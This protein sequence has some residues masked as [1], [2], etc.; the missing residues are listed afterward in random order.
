MS[1]VSVNV[2]NI[3]GHILTAIPPAV[4]QYIDDRTKYHPD[5]YDKT[6]TYNHR[7]AQG[8]RRWDGFNHTFN[9]EQR[10][11]RR[12]LLQRVY[13]ALTFHGYAPS[14][15]Q[16]GTQEMQ[17]TTSISLEPGVVT[18]YPFQEKVR[19][20]IRTEHK[21]GIIA[22]PT[23]TGKSVMMGLMCD[24]LRERTLII[25]NDLVLCDQMHRNLQRYFPKGD[26]GYI[27]NAEFQLGEVT[28]A[29]LQSLRSILG[30][31]EKKSTAP[32]AHIHELLQ[33]LKGVG[34]VLHDEVHLADCESNI[35]VYDTL[36]YTPRRF[37]FSATPYGW[38]EK[39]QKYAN[40]EL[41]QLFGHIIYSTFDQD[42]VALG[43]KVPVLVR[44]IEVPALIPVYGTFRDNQGVLYKKCLKL[45]ILENPAWHAAV[46]STAREYTEN[47]ATAFVYASHSLKYGQLIAD[48]LEAPFVNGKT[49]RKERFR[50]FDAVQAKELPCIVSDI[51][52][53]GLDIPSLDAFILASDSKD[54]R[55]MRGRVERAS[56]GKEYG[57]FCDLWKNTSFLKSH[58]K[59][60]LNQYTHDDATII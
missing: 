43:L 49:P 56:P 10:T 54:V 17:V 27:G 59:T 5:G 47:G 46:K 3:W 16:Y 18:P 57:H 6:W 37:G 41:E 22:S 50:L 24:E 32:S 28:V 58:H 11:F 33:W 4:L 20:F 39:Q 38:A 53:I 1:S 14:I 44:N 12:G 30:V 2:D 29:T 21:I 31:I 35:A 9:V 48:M 42:F 55:Q 45:E 8:N 40:L 23:G 34:M 25:L 13:E 26:I 36:V 15:A 7:D 51:G 52:G 19:E 60:R